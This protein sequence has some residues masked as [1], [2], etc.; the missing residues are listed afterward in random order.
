MVAQMTVERSTTQMYITSALIE[1]WFAL[2]TAIEQERPTYAQHLARFLNDA[3][4]QT[5]QDIFTRLL[6]HQTVV[7]ASTIAFIQAKV[8]K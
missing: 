3:E 5:V 8:A 1:R 6:L 2:A 4:I 7:W